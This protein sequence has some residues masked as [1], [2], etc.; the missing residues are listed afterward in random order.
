MSLF[1][2]A[3]D[4]QDGMPVRIT[5]V[6]NQF[7]DFPEDDRKS[8]VPQDDDADV[9][10]STATIGDT[11]PAYRF[12]SWLDCDDPD[13][14]A[15]EDRF[16]LRVEVDLSDNEEEVDEFSSHS[17]DSN[18]AYPFKFVPLPISGHATDCQGTVP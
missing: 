13:A 15:M 9:H 14:L 1:A 10:N 6:E 7:N 11:V 16:F 4:A 2:S 3:L 18:P 12:L 8:A 5:E 17:C